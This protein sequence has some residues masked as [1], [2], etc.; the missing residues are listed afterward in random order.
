MKLVFFAV[1]GYLALYLT[2]VE[3]KMPPECLGVGP[4]ERTPSYRIF[5]RVGVV[6]FSPA[7]WVDRRV[8]V[9]F[10]LFRFEATNDPPHFE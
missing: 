4:W 10:W 7:E 6:F 5:G 9:E 1:I 2:L 3:P 8:R